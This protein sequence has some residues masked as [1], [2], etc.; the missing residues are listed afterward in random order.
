MTTRVIKCIKTLGFEAFGSKTPFLQVLDCHNSSQR[1]DCSLGELDP[2]K[3]VFTRLQLATASSNSPRK[4]EY[5]PR[6]VDSAFVHCLL[7]SGV[8]G[9]FRLG[10]SCVVFLQKVNPSNQGS[11]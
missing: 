11:I 3:G 4:L 8:S 7:A 1:A 2:Q 6:R 9:G 10:F 5:S